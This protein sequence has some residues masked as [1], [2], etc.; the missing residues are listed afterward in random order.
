[1]SA[2]FGRGEPISSYIV[3]EEGGPTAP[4]ENELELTLFSPHRMFR[5]TD[6]DGA[7]LPV[8]LGQE[9][10]LN[11]VTVFVEIPPGEKATVVVT[12]RGRLAPTDGLYSLTVARQP[13]PFPDLIEARIVGAPG[14]RLPE[15]G[16]A[17]LVSDDDRTATLEATFSR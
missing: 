10:G 6:G 13:V 16:A 5:V 9:R 15:G 8:S 7:V 17:G 4:G 2:G 14:W 3:G 12:F 11:A 1:M